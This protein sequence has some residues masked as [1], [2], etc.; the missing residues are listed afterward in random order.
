[1]RRPPRARRRSSL[2][3]R[4]LALRAVDDVHAVVLLHLLVHARR[5]LI[6]AAAA[7]GRIDQAADPPLRADVRGRVVG[8]LR[9]RGL[10]RSA[11]QQ[12]GD[13]ERSDH[14]RPPLSPSAP[15]AKRNSTSTA[16][17]RLAKRFATRPSA[18]ASVC[19][20]IASAII[21]IRSRSPAL[22]AGRPKRARS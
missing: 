22:A 10:R 9:G 2:L 8:A 6:A 15:T 17:S 19:A 4:V 16:V 3:R 21:A 14:R 11:A 5:A 20:T 12:Q 18:R 1:R 13:R 7:V